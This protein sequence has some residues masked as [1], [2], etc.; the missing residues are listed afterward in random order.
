MHSKQCHKY[1]AG[2]AVRPVVC[3]NRSV[4]QTVSFFRRHSEERYRLF[5][6]Q[7]IVS[8][9]VEMLRENLIFSL[10]ILTNRLL[11]SIKQVYYM[12]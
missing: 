7:K 6:L 8:C 9:S 1:S 3:G 10:T 4:W 11:Y 2:M 5:A 12:E